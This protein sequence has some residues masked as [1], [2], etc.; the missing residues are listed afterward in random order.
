MTK[1]YL[2]L[3]Y[4]RKSLVLVKDDILCECRIFQTIFCYG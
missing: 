1:F 2:S 3:E 4:Y